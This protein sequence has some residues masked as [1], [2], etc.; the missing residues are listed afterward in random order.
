[1]GPHLFPLTSGLDHASCTLPKQGREPN[2]SAH[3]DP[4][5]QCPAWLLKSN[6]MFVALSLHC[7][8]DAPLPSQACGDGTCVQSLHQCHAQ[9]A[10]ENALR[11]RYLYSA[12]Y[13]CQAYTAL[14]SSHNKHESSLHHHVALA[15]HGNAE[16]ER[17]DH[18]CSHVGQWIGAD[19][20]PQSKSTY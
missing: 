9:A 19:R 11:L 8:T 7:F 3:I 15:A 6:K 13:S 18:D 4:S 2:L 5:A 14:L 17:S 16:A 1:M 20:G 10:C 12:P